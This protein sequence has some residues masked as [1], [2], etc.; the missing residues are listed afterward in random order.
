MDAAQQIPVLKIEKWEY[1]SVR[2]LVSFSSFAGL[3]SP[4]PLV[5]AAYLIPKITTVSKNFSP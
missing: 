5:R 1:L 3:S 4:P 2:L